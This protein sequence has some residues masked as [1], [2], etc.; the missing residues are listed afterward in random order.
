M[1]AQYPQ[2]D[3]LSVKTL[4]LTLAVLAA[5]A[6]VAVGAVVALAAPGSLGRA[7]SPQSSA[8]GS[9]YCPAGLKKQLKK[10]IAAYRKRITPDRRRYFKSHRSAKQ[11]SRF[12]KLQTQQLKTLQRKL[13]KC[14]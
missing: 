13:G 9:V 5:S 3:P 10:T 8:A 6:L 4:R 7:A 11:R 1:P 2:G 14:S 12:A